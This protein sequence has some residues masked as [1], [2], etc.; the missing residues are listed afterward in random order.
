L[1][2]QGTETLKKMDDA[3]LKAMVDS[4]K[5]NKE[6][7]RQV[8][9]AQGMEMSDEQLDAFANMMTP[10][11]LKS[12]SQML[13]RNP[14]LLNKVKAPGTAPQPGAPQPQEEEKGDP[15]GNPMMQEMLK[16]PDLM[17]Q[18]AAMMGGGENKSLA[19]MVQNPEFLDNALRMIKDPRNKAML[20]MMKQQNPNMNVDMVVKALE[21]VN[22]LAACYRA[23][24]N[25]WNNVLVRLLFF[26]F[27]VLLIAYYFG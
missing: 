17:K 7:M 6:Q 5:N 15:M 26:G 1:V 14:D 8:Y 20:D 21:G 12:A 23:L 2:K 27:I 11:M 9:R 22:K 4:M 13:E 25:A 18:A 3:Q 24:R 10:D 19:G 16:N